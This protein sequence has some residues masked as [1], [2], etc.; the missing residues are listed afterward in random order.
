MLPVEQHTHP[1]HFETVTQ[2][3]LSGS[4]V[5]TCM[6][7]MSLPRFGGHG[8]CLVVGTSTGFLQIHGED[9]VVLHRQDVHQGPL[10]SMHINR[11]TIAATSATAKASIDA[12]VGPAEDVTIGYSHGVIKVHAVDI[13]SVVQWA[14]RGESPP[15]LDIEKWNFAKGGIRRG[16]A[17]VG[18]CNP[19]S[20]YDALSQRRE[21]HKQVILSIGRNPPIAFY[22]V[23]E[24]NKPGV[25][26]SLVS[27]IMSSRLFTRGTGRKAA[28]GPNPT[29]MEEKEYRLDVEQEDDDLVDEGEELQGEHGR[30]VVHGTRISSS[31]CVWDDA[32]RNAFG[33]AI[34]PGG[35]WAACCDSL[36]RVLVIDV[37]ARSIHRMLKG[38]REVQ[39]I[40][41]KPSDHKHAVSPWPLFLMLYAPKRRVIEVWDVFAHTRVHALSKGIPN[42]GVLVAHAPYSGSVW[43]LDIE[44]YHLI[45][46]AARLSG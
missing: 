9:G 22:E 12:G 19:T 43:L 11:T 7:Y 13:F 42:A 17:H 10:T 45:D 23:E 20:L 3:S 44:R 26:S 37:L 18:Y 41:W 4:D 32:K 27:S 40:W 34:C 1:V 5:I 30:I 16:S 21:S 35:R 31:C 2:E 6:E 8:V 28:V 36:G 33:L 15:Q 29:A 25:I 14:L 24:N 39:I 46:V 38:Y